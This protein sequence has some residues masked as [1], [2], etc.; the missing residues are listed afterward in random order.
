MYISYN[1]IVTY[2][3]NVVVVMLSAFK[4]MIPLM[5]PNYIIYYMF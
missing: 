5:A 1:V 3:V 4:K 2:I